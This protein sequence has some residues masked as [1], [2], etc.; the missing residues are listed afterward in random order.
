MKDVGVL[1]RKSIKVEDGSK[2][3]RLLPKKPQRY[4]IGSGG[5]WCDIMTP[6]IGTVFMCNLKKCCVKAD[7]NNL[8]VDFASDISL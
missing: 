2:S 5:W 1:S 6:T 3:K 4:D 7:E 8:V